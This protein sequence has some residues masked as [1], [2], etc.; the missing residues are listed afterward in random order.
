M[1]IGDFFKAI[2]DFFSGKKKEETK[3]I[4][5]P[6]IVAPVE[7]EAPVIE[8]PPVVETPA[9]VEVESIKVEEPTPIKVEPIKPVEVPTTSPK[10]LALIIGHSKVDGGA[11]GVAPLNKQEYAYNT[12]VARIA[13]LESKAMGVEIGIFTR[14]NG[15]IKGAYSSATKWLDSMGKKGAIIE[16]HFNAANGVAV[17]TETLYAD[18]KDEKGVN[19]KAFA[20]AIQDEMCRVFSRETKGNRGLKREI[21]AKGERGYSNLSQTV[22]YP[23]L[24]VEPFFGDVKTETK[25]AVERQKEYAMCLVT[26]FL[27]FAQGIK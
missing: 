9:P 26:G 17:G 6:V 23:S 14:D 4:E 16:L 22:K 11:E 15:G 19:E 18:V 25:M 13:Q 1:S 27:K 3:P 20:Q 7:P 5:T 8:A 12:E 21:G 2:L 10:Y 24:I